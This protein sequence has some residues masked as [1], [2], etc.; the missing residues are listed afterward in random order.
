MKKCLSGILTI[1]L[2]ALPCIPLAGCGSS[3]ID[4]VL[5]DLPIAVDIAASVINIVSPG[6]AE[7]TKEV[8]EY[9]GKVSGD[10]KLIESL[11]GQYKADLAKAPAGVVRQINAALNDCQTNPGPI[12]FTFTMQPLED[13]K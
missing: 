9:A 2:I 6:D 4:T 11:I 8:T 10:L 1:L 12:E 3:V 5:E 13:A 7:L